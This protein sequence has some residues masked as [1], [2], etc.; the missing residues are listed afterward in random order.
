MFFSPQVFVLLARD[1]FLALRKHFLLQEK[2]LAARKKC[3][4]AVSR[5]HFQGIRN[6]VCG[7]AVLSG[8]IIEIGWSL[9]F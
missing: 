6:Y 1:F 8:Q 2:I 3:F 7:R 4:A 5:K 9:G